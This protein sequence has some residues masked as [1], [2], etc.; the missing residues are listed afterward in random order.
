[1]SSNGKISGFGAEIHNFLNLLTDGGASSTDKSTTKQ[2]VQTKDYIVKRG[3][4]MTEIA[5]KT[6]QNL[7]DL[8]RKNPQIKNPNKI[9]VGQHI[10]IGGG[11]TQI[12]TVKRGDTLS[13]I[14]KKY[15]T[16][17]GDILRAN[18]GQI[19]NRNL[20]YPGQK[21]N[22]PSAE[23]QKQTQTAKPTQ[24]KTSPTAK[25][26]TPVEN[27][28]TAPHKTNPPVG[29]TPK[30]T[31]QSGNL[32]IKQID[33]D[34]FLSPKKG[35][36]A[37]YAILIGNAEGNR[38]ANG[39]KTDHY[40]GHRDPGDGKWNIGSFSY[41]NDRKG[42]KQAKSPED[43]DR[44]Q[45]GRLYANKDVYAAA[46]K[47]A[48]LDPN[49]ALLATVYLDMFNQSPTSAEL[50]LK[51]DNLKYLKDNGI[52]IETM[53]EWRYRGFINPETGKQRIT[54]RGKLAGG[55]LA[56]GNLQD[57]YAGLANRNAL[58]KYH[59]LATPDELK[60]LIRRDQNRRVDE[61]IKPLKNI[62]L[63]SINKPKT[64][65]KPKIIETVN[66]SNS[67][68]PSKADNIKANVLIPARG[69]GFI[70][71]NRDGNDQFGTAR[72]IE[73]IQTIA[74]IWH[75]NNP[76]I[77]IQ[78]GDISRKGGGSF[79]PIHASHKNG[80]DVDIR[81]IR[82]DGKP[83]PLN[84]QNNPNALD[85]DK[86]RELIKVIR[87]VNPNAIIYFN[88]PVLIKEGLTTFMKGHFNHIHVRF[89]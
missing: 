74:K 3:D 63:L 58:K 12:Y 85:R 32:K 36:D 22:I 49:N 65:P 1:M 5:V 16:G 15:K 43:A 4:T 71:Y 61:M 48:G 87:Q 21:L 39:D 78:I 45:L 70:T 62:G 77:P 41:S 66:N 33:L 46:M 26:Q 11:Q 28:P 75:K 89:K 81:P 14:A 86:M 10:K 8:I 79:R 51:P 20:I 68:S 47:K 2:S 24:K 50:L 44:I 9:Y 88:D 7:Q 23:R 34:E 60:A 40:Y 30:Q 80:I 73:N 27:K 55:N 76:N 82:K 52:T 59:R 38:R 67:I 64:E 54:S 35:S 17:I 42:A 72:T 29:T 6:G 53:K 19:A 13:D 69:R 57:G 18:P 37:G 25:P 31:V 56:S 83:L 84:I